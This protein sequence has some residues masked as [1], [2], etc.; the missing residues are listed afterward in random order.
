[1]STPRRP[2]T[3][4]DDDLRAGWEAAAG[5][6]T[7]TVDAGA[8][9]PSPERIW[10][11]A[12]GELGPV[13]AREVV[14]HMAACPACAEAWRLARRLGAATAPAARTLELRDRAAAARPSPGR[15]WWL[16]AVAAALVATLGIGLREVWMPDGPATFR[17][18]ETATVRPLV[19]DGATLP[20]DRFELAWEAVPEAL[21]YDLRLTTADLVPMEVRR[22]LDAPRHRVPPERLAALDAG[23]RLF[24]QVEVVLADGGR[25]ISPSFEVVL[26]PPAGRAPP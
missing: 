4:S 24:W 1:M 11:A 16:A 22:G 17:G 20:R 23:S 5:G 19:A 10:A 14:D 18:S 2:P 25:E 7:A 3:L 9:C 21:E 6:D 26:G 8:A 12:H 15:P 13:E